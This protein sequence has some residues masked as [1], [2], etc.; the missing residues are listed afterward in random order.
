MKTKEKSR[1]YKVEYLI[2]FLKADK[3]GPSYPYR[4]EMVLEE[5]VEENAIKAYFENQIA[6][7]IAG[8]NEFPVEEVNVEIT[9][10]QEILA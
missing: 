8:F 4:K 7:L 5:P 3:P 2:Y 1:K 9:S 10:M 6:R